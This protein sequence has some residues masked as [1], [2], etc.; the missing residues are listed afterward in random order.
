MSAENVAPRFGPIPVSITARMQN[1]LIDTYTAGS[2]Q[3]KNYAI[4]LAEDLNYSGSRV[5]AFISIMGLGDEADITAITNKFFLTGMQLGMREKAQLLET[6]GGAYLSFFGQAAPV[7]QFTGQALEFISEADPHSG[8][9]QSA[10]TEL[11]HTKLRGT[12]LIKERSIAILKVQNH[13]IWGFPL[14]YQ[15]GYSSNS[16]KV[17]NFSMSW[18]VVKHD[19]IL[20]PARNNFSALYGQNS[21]SN[22][23]SELKSEA[24]EFGR[25]IKHLSDALHQMLQ[26]SSTEE[27]HIASV[28]LYSTLRDDGYLLTDP[29]TL[30]E[31][32]KDAA[33]TEIAAAARQEISKLQ[34][35]LI[36]LRGQ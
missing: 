36:A 21:L 8:L 15:V 1:R 34:N 24:D 6:F 33:V 22:L 18:A 26:S 5:G 14:N 11:Y 2:T 30:T 29:A 31:T 12:Q 23:S 28:H 32:A 17:T 13:H 4:D 10:L 25:R 27:S 9:H 7:Y 16:E 19:Q 3:S 20:S 35:K